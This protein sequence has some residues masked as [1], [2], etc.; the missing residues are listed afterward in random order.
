MNNYVF[1]ILAFWGVL[2]LPLERGSL[3]VSDVQY[4]S[5]WLL[6]SSTWLTLD[7]FQPLENIIILPYGKNWQSSIL[8]KISL[9]IERPSN[10][11]ECTKDVYKV[12]SC[13][14]CRGN[15]SYF[16]GWANKWGLNGT[17]DHYSVNSTEQLWCLK[18]CGIECRFGWL[19]MRKQR[20]TLQSQSILT[21]DCIELCVNNARLYSL[22][23]SWLLTV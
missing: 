2:G 16:L 18:V 8:L 17:N 23:A 9:T 20:N 3:P 21:I 5:Q 1:S 19:C 14:L 10:W 12:Q 6:V 15:M 11:R 4:C 22:S 13:A 7:D